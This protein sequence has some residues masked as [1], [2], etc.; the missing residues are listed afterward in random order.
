MRSGARRGGG[1]RRVGQIL[2][3]LLA[4]S[5][6]AEASVPGAEDAVSLRVAPRVEPPK[7][8]I[9]VYLQHDKRVR[10]LA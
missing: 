2:V 10:A 1:A 5:Q 8:V 3:R 4:G 6:Q 9:E 7:Y